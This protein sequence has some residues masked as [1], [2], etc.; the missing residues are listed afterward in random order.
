MVKEIRNVV[1]WLKNWFYDKNEV[2]QKNETYTKTEVDTSLNTK[3]NSNLT[4]ANKMLVTDNNGNVVLD[5]KPTFEAIKVVATLPTASASTMGALYIVSENSK[6]NVYYTRN[7]N[8]SYSWQK[9]DTDILD[10]LSVGWNDITGKPSTFTPSSHASPT[11]V[12]G[13]ASTDNFGHLRIIDDL[14]ASSYSNGVCLSAHQGYVL[15]NKIDAMVNDL[16]DSYIVSELPDLMRGN[17]DSDGLYIVENRSGNLE[18]YAYKAPT[19]E[20]LGDYGS[21]E[22]LSTINN[23]LPVIELVPKS[24][25][26]T[27]A[28]RFYYGDEP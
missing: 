10:D 13:L 2:Y 27:G 4:V 11:P 28:I 12:Y 21:W 3:L 25:D 19:S 22:L 17:Y 20:L 15:N 23:P 6:V 5:D 8:G 1:T 26:A 18:I 24:T 14:L 16:R 9:M 7:N